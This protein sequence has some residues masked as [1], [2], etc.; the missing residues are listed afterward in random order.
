[1][2]ETL[3]D[4]TRLAM[5]SFLLASMLEFGLGL[6]IR[7][8]LA[9][10]ADVRRLTLSL[11]ANFLVAPLLAVVIGRLLRLEEPHAIGLLVLGLAPGAPFIP[12]VVQLARGDVAL[13]VTLMVLLMVGTVACLPLALPA[14]LAGVKVDAWAIGQKL[15]LLML[16]PL[17]TGL[18]LRAAVRS[19]PSWL[20]PALRRLSGVSGLVVMA[21][22]VALQFES[23]LSVVG[24]GAI[25][26][27][28]LFTI[29]SSL[30]GWAIGGADRSVRRALGLATGLRNV[31]AA[32]LVAAGNF[33]DPGVGVMVIVSALVGMLLLVPAAWAVGRRT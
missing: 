4:V 20:A 12:K 3:L 31:A 2:K 33:Q 24:T 13:S 15:F 22:I 5:L 9:P 16:L 11:G 26:A 21:L 1:V 14:I 27:G 6:G 8:V 10:L 29:L 17:F 19:L 23:V 32:I 28:A 7:Q 25:F 18:A 30:A